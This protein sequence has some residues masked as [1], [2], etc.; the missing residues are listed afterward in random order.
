MI[1]LQER[2]YN[3][4]PREDWQPGKLQQVFKVRRRHKNTGMQEDNLLSLSY[5]RIVNKDIDTAEGLL[6]ESFET[7]QIVDPGN[8]VMRLTDLQNDKR[9]LRQGFVTQRG[10]ITSAYDALEVGK[11]HDPRFWFYVLLA[12]DLAKYYYSLGGGVRQ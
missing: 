8:I 9:S 10:I 2:V 6:P 5:G 11:K 3:I 4:T 1:T 12:L 7:Y